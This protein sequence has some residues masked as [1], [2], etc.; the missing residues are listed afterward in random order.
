MISPD[1]LLTAVTHFCLLFPRARVQPWNEI[2]SSVLV[3]TGIAS[4]LD[5][6]HS[7]KPSD[8]ITSYKVR[9]E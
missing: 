8:K 9:K 6:K 1:I 4:I 2:I 3:T 7:E 5:L